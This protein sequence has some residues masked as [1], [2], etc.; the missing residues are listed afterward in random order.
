MKKILSFIFFS[1][2]FALLT[3]AEVPQTF[4][5]QAVVRSADG[6]L[7]QEKEISVKISILQNSE[8]GSIVFTETREVKTNENGL[9]TF[10]I[11]DQNQNLSSIDWSDGPYFIQCEIDP[12]GGK[13]YALSLT[14][15]LM[16]VPYALYA[17]HVSKNAIPDWITEEKP[18]YQYDEIQNTP[19]IPTKTSELDND[20]GYIT[21]KEI[22]EF[23][24]PTKVSELENDAKYITLADVPAANIPTK[25]SELENDANYVQKSDLP[26]TKGL[27]S[28]AEAQNTYQPKGNYLTEH[29]SLEGYALKSDIPSLDS[30]K[31]AVNGLLSA[32]DAESLYQP[33]GEYLTEHQSLEAYALKSEIPNTAGLLSATDAQNTYQPKG[34]YLTEH[35]SLEGYALKSD[36]PN[37][38]TLK[39]AINNMLS[40]SEAKTLYQ[41]KGEY[42]TEHQSLA[43]YAKKSEI[44]STKGLLTVEEAQDT[45]Q[46]KGNYLT[47]HQSLEGY[48]LKSEIPNVD[49]LL[50]E[51]KAQTLYQPKGEYLTE[52]QSLAAYAL[53]SE[54]P[55][56]AGLLSAAEAQSTYQPKGNYL[57]EHQSLDSY[58]KRSEIPTKVSAFANDVKYLTRDSLS[59]NI[60][61]FTNDANYITLNDVPA[62]PTKVSQLENDKQYITAESVPTK[63]SAFTNDANYI[64]SASLNELLSAINKKLDSLSQVNKRLEKQLDSL[65]NPFGQPESTNY[66][67]AT[68]NSYNFST[69]TW[70][71]GP[72]IYKALTG[73]D[74][75]IYL[76]RHSERGSDY[77][78]TG[79]L[80]ENGIKLALETGE[81]YKGGLA[82]TNESFYGSTHVYRCKQTSYYIS[83][84]RGD[85]NL[86]DSSDVYNPIEELKDK[87]I[88]GMTSIQSDVSHFY[89]RN[90][91]SVQAKGIEIITKICQLSNGY[92]F[93]WFTTHDYL[94]VPLCEW[95]TEEKI[96][97]RQSQD[98][99]INFM[100][101]LAI[102]VHKDGTWEA[103]PVRNLED[104]YKSW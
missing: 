46:P 61:T 72:D 100:T 88:V 32:S 64:T 43:E 6:K 97:F 38:D 33:K 77:S 28:A 41:P 103:Y 47:Q 74:R 55:S 56:T 18:T 12:T 68:T 45:Y 58:A 83:K 63:V 26:D 24:A 5:Y 79:V 94:M 96:E 14:T 4:S 98:H 36:I 59:T 31:G 91:E 52:H 29:Q 13:N 22:P 49:T 60:S 40:A 89:E 8:T 10:A 102:I 75:I 27:L 54:I 15:Q 81:K 48:A 57:I 39:D 53:K 76:V 67:R 95:I 80:N 70:N 92:R 30:L 20:N 25:V 44:P 99:W 35:Q 34:N 16:S 42:L 23:T 51:G 17:E 104:G 78:D 85:T 101:G 71:Y 84:G 2:F 3:F 50:S 65:R 86:S 37:L 82:K 90:K 69:S 11:G 73:T 93:A 9:M 66:Q 62:A 21:L 7:L 19:V 87:Y 1:L